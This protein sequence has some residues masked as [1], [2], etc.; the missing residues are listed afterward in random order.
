MKK[1]YMFFLCAFVLI[2]CGY[3]QWF[4]SDNFKFCWKVD[5]LK[6]KVKSIIELGYELEK[7]SGVIK[8]DSGSKNTF[9]YDSIGNRIKDKYSTSSGA[10]NSFTYTYNEEGNPFEEIFHVGD[11]IHSSSSK[12]YDTRNNLV[13]ETS[14]SGSNGK[15]SIDSFIY[16]YDA[17]GKI[18]EK[19]KYNN[20]KFSLKFNYKYN[21]KGSL[22]EELTFLNNGVLWIKQIFKYDLN[23]RPMER[24]QYVNGKL[25][26]RVNYKYDTIGNIVEEI[27]YRT[28]N[29]ISTTAK[30]LNI[31]D[32]NGNKIEIIS[33]GETKFPLATSNK[34]YK[35]TE[36]YEY[37]ERG[38]W[39]KKISYVN[40]RAGI[41]E[42]E[43]E[44][45]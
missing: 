23:G 28:I 40:G 38:N 27:D 10:F 4:A 6:G 35:E 19:T 25:Q 44:F 1:V 31:Y 37:D 45:Y 13:E 3:S 11:S 34:K 29:G 22:V 39:V 41:T 30:K 17:K 36:K 15:T 42:R 8:K 5:N 9:Y 20:G 2:N 33:S 26:W 43:Y 18:I 14:Y 24:I 7:G 21:S 32:K 12:K 16:K